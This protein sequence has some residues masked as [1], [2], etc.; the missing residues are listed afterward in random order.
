[1]HYARQGRQRRQAGSKNEH[2]M[3]EV[4]WV[5]SVAGRLQGVPWLKGNSL[6]SVRTGL[7]LAYGSE[8][9]LPTDLSE[10]SAPHSLRNRP[11]HCRGHRGR[12]LEAA[13][14]GRGQTGLDSTPMPPL[15][16]ARR[17]PRTV[18]CIHIC[19]TASCSGIDSTTR[20][21]AACID[22]GRSSTS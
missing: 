21:R 13:R 18:P 6:L 20:C 3:T 11:R 22:M 10:D 17:P 19:G 7:K 4:E 14:G 16:T 12:A 1:M 8:I 5:A 2:P 9:K 15:P